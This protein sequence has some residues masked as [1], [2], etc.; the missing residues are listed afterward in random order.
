MEKLKF[1]PELEIATA[2]SRMSKRWR[3]RRCRWSELVAR[4]SE[5]ARTSETVAEYSRMSRDEQSRVK[6]VGGLVGGYLNDGLRKTAAVRLRTLITLDIDNGAAAGWEE[7]KRTQP[8]AAMVYTTHTHTEAAP[9]FR[10]LMPLA[11]PVTPEEYEPVARRVAQAI[12]IEAVDHTSYRVAQLAYWPSTSRDGVFFRDVQDGPTLDPDRVLASYTDWRNASEWPVSSKEGEARRHE[13]RRAGEPTER[14]GLIGAF[15][16]AYTIE[17]AIDTFLAEVYEPTAQEG[18]YTYTGGHLSGGLVCYGGKFAY[19]H[20]NTDPAGGLLCNAFDLVRIH[21]FGAADEGKNP[22]DVTRLP[23]YARMM[24]LAGEDARVRRLLAE[25]RVAQFDGCGEECEHSETTESS[26]DSAWMAELDYDRKGEI[27]STARNIMLILE[28]DPALTGHLWHDLFSSF[29]MVDGGLPWDR[30]ARQWSNRDDANLRVYMERKYGITGKDRIKDA[31]DAVLTRHRRHPIREYLEALR[32]DGVERLDRLIIDTLGAE[33]SALNRAMTRK[34]FT[35]AVARVMEPGCKYDY[36]LILTGP[37]GIGKSTLFSVMGGEW[38]NDSL[39]TTEGKAGM[40]QLR[41]GWIYEL[42]ELSSIKR[43]DVEQ[44]KN[45]ISRQADIYRAAY[46]SVVERYPRQCV[47]CGTTNEAKFLK[48][49]TGN[50]RFW[51]M[52]VTAAGDME[53]VR[54]ARDQL[55]AEAVARYRAGE[56]LYLPRDLEAEARGRQSEFNDDADDPL[57]ELLAA[58][59]DAKLPPGWNAWD[60]NRRRAWLRNPDPL[61]A[62]GTETRERVCPAEFICERMGM[63]MT[64]PKYKYLARRIGSYIREMGWEGPKC[65]RHA[66]G[67]YGIQYSYMRNVKEDNET[68]A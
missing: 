6:D 36:C 33:D 51:V 44:V 32:W 12:G 37:E 14:P 18:R 22:E 45:Y 23:S 7:F 48:G 30:E 66:M 62:E 55:W 27:K 28:R 3:N 4:C 35:A 65:S 15:C 52:A 67:L 26:E 53:A 19:S 38:F 16:R 68:S 10:L 63:D 43:S 64:D 1:D 50:R 29:D 11:R 60:L 31:K 5:T 61:E 47:F 56:K 13:I 34:H 46:G 24:E 25:E 20:H 2:P 21:R 54:G 42:A 39:T 41:A 58:F 40:E 57:R 9:R 8:W 17:D 49:E 59:L